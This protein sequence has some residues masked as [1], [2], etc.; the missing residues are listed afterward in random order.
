MEAITEEAKREAREEEKKQPPKKPERR[1]TPPRIELTESEPPTGEAEY[2]DEGIEKGEKDVDVGK[3]ETDAKTERGIA[4]V[5]VVEEEEEISESVTE[6]EEIFQVSEDG[7]HWKTVKKITTITPR[8]TTERVVVLGGIR[9]TF[10]LPSLQLSMFSS[11][12]GVI[13]FKF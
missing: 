8:G 5:A 12:Y 1:R 3:D 13:L 11:V 7:V 6:I 4:D 10:T 2:E 9:Y